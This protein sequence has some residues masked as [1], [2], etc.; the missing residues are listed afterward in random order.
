LKI[1]K[2]LDTPSVKILL[3]IREKGEVQHLELAKVTAS[4]STLSLSLTDLE[5]AGL[6]KRRLVATKPV[7]SFY[8]LTEKGVSVAEQLRRLKE[9]LLT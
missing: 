9:S 4:R 6:V 8:S 3:F 2:I 1:E 7:Q 5:E